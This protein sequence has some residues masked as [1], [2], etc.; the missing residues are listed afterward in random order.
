MPENTPNIVTNR[1][2]MH[3]LHFYA[4]LIFSMPPVTLLFYIPVALPWSLVTLLLPYPRHDSVPLLRCG[5]FHATHTSHL[6]PASS[7]WHA[8]ASMQCIPVGIE[9]H[10]YCS[11][12]P[13]ILTI[14]MHRRAHKHNVYGQLIKHDTLTNEQD[15]A[16][17]GQPGV[18]GGGSACVTC[19]TPR[20]SSSCWQR[21]RG[22]T[23]SHSWM[24]LLVASLCPLTNRAWTW[25]LVQ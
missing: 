1:E 10:Y 3:A 11:P 18:I 24:W 22:T 13:F 2:V 9:I 8:P 21:K 4:P 17:P 19:R 12:S 6:R 16:C 25:Q 14:H 23:I 20:L 15:W 7:L 5:P